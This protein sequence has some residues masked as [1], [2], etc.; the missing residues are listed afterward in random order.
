ML[1]AIAIV[2]VLALLV[3]LTRDIFFSPIN[4]LDKSTA[5]CEGTDMLIASTA[6]YRIIYPV[7]HAAKAAAKEKLGKFRRAYGCYYVPETEWQRYYDELHH[8]SCPV[9]VWITGR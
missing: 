3:Y 9:A 7:S 4:W 5:K 2:A 1:T 6:K 8:G